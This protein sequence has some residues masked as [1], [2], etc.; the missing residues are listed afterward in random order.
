V[1]C[2]F[3]AVK[4]HASPRR[5][6]DNTYPLSVGHNALDVSCLSMGQVVLRL[7][8]TPLKCTMSE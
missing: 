3:N 6:L 2:L 7:S 8:S 1:S 4:P 5:V